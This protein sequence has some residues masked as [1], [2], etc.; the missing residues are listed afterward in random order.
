MTADDAFARAYTGSE[1]WISPQSWM[2]KAVEAPLRALNAKLDAFATKAGAVALTDA[3]VASIGDKVAAAVVA[4][5][6]NPLSDAD[7]P[8]II[9]AVKAALRQ[10]TAA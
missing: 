1:A 9:A 5:P 7:A 3:Q 4:H 10:G 8:V 6:D 2:A